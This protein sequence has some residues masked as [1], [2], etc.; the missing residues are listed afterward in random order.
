MKP[1]RLAAIVLCV[2]AIAFTLTCVP[3]IVA[4]PASFGPYVGFF[5][6]L[7]LVFGALAL[8]GFGRVARIGLGICT[9]SF[10]AAQIVY[11]RYTAS[12]VPAWIPPSQVFWT[13]ITTV[14][15]GLAAIAMLANLRA[16]LAMQLMAAMI[17]LFG[18]LVWVPRLV[19]HP[20]R[21]FNWSEFALNFLIAVTAW[22]AAEARSA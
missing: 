18:V 4:A 2:V 22:V 19:A 16:R 8:C 10:A 6:Y 21:Q 9:I 7:S 3:A 17:V 13:I 1:A 11:F 20:E 14:A 12:L 15:F 5:E